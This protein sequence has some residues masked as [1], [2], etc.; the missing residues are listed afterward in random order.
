LTPQCVRELRPVLVAALLLVSLLLAPT[1][2]RADGVSFQDLEESLTCQCGCGLTVHSCNHLQCPS[3]IPLREEI[4]AQMT[5]GKS[6]EAIL[7]YFA[8]KYGEKI[9]SA[10]TATG[11]NLLAWTTPFVLLGIAGVVLGITV[12]RWTR[13]GQPPA[14]SEPKPVSRETSSYEKIIERELKNFDR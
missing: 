4:R 12:T 5:D 2:V 6:K 3:A 13:R 7:A 9:L 8:D 11:F 14:P 1:Q 10:P